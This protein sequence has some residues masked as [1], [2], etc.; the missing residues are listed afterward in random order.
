MRSIP[1]FRRTATEGMTGTSATTRRRWPR[2][3]LMLTL[4]TVVILVAAVATAEML[5]WRFL[6]PLVQQTLQRTSHKNVQLQDFRLRLIGGP[7]LQVGSITIAQAPAC[8]S[9]DPCTASPAPNTTAAQQ[10]A[11]LTSATPVLPTPHAATPPEAL[12]VARGLSVL[13]RWADL[14]RAWPQREVPL[15][16][17]HADYW[18]AWVERD[19]QGHIL[20][21]QGLTSNA[22]DA[23]SPTWTPRIEQLSLREGMIQ[24][25]EPSQKTSLDL[26]VA[27]QEAADS[28]PPPA[29]TAAPAAAK[30][31]AKTKVPATPA[32]TTDASTTTAAAKTPAEGYQA[33]VQGT[34]QHKAMNLRI[35]SSE[36]LPIFTG[37]GQHTVRATIEGTVAGVKIAFDGSTSSLAS[38]N[39]LAGSFDVRG[40]SL[41]TVGDVLHIALPQTGAFRL[42][43]TLQRQPSSW[44]VQARSIDIGTSHLQA[45]MALHDAQ[46]SGGRALLQGTLSGSRL[47]LADLAPS[48]AGSGERTVATTTNGGAKR[49][50]PSK[51]FNLPALDRMDARIDI[52]IQELQLNPGDVQPMTQVRGKLSLDDGTLSITD[53]HTLLANGS[54]TGN[55][56]LR[57]KTAP[58]QWD[59]QWQFNDVD[60]VTLVPALRIHGAP[61]SKPATSSHRKAPRAP[62]RPPA[63]SAYMSGRANIQASMQG[64]GNS[65]ADILA[66]LQGSLQAN[67]VNGTLSHL[68]TELVGLDLAQSLGIFVRGDEALVLHCAK[69]RI[70]IRQGVATPRYLILDNSDS[71]IIV[72]GSVD[73]RQEALRLTV[74][75]KPKDFSFFT[76]RAPIHIAGTFAQPTVKVDAPVV[77]GKVLAG[78]VLGAA[79]G[80]IGAILPFLDVGEDSVKIPCQLSPI[81]RTA[82]AAKPAPPR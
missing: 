16:R 18:Y 15:E 52:D 66:S 57:G 65:T 51:A 63:A 35:R 19:A 70:D 44:Q 76:V 31:S 46:G 4:G 23:N 3:L 6:E 80:G 1:F 34:W 37:K 79:T 72:D 11:P 9:A 41:A 71:Q 28:T 73:L 45:D 27:G 21:L 14:V 30:T 54:V 25:R 48:I 38:P 68:L 62:Q 75:S 33:T 60:L 55:T 74:R 7:R 13:A 17:I 67:V 39:G 32:Q 53:F 26:Q 24:Y 40:P 58:A 36:L 8:A 43:G 82:P 47:A 22:T 61:A 59:A 29:S 56:T 81:Q 78:V 12:M 42:R 64:A 50:L 2:R 49:V 20:G 77:A 10:A 5:E 69:T